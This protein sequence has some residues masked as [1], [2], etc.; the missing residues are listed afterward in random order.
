MGIEK[1]H[2]YQQA[3]TLVKEIYHL[4]ETN[5]K[6]Q[7]DFSLCDQIKRAAVS[8]A[9]NISEGYLRSTKQSKNYLQIASGSSNEVVTLLQVIEI[10]YQ[11]DVRDLIGDYQT[12]G[13]Q[14]GSYSRFLSH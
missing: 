8:V 13:K 5:K 2:I 1:L 11:A 4:I 12:L 10:I 6:L 7:K 9:T 3:L 14:I